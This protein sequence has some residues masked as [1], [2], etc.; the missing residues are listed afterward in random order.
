MV[1]FPETRC[2]GLNN[3]C[4]ANTDENQT[5]LHQACDDG[6]QGQ[7]KGTGTFECDTTSESTRNGPAM[8]DVTTQGKAPDASETC[9][10]EDNDCDGKTDEGSETGSLLGQEWVDIGGGR[11][12]M[13]Y[14]ASRQDATDTQQGTLAG[15]TVSSLVA[16][17]AGA[18]ES[19]TTATFTTVAPHG[20]AVGQKVRV[21]GVAVS[22]YN[23]IWTVAT[24]PAATTFTATVTT[25]GLAA[26]G[27]GSVTKYIGACSKAG[28]QPWT[29]VT[30]PEA[31]AV[32]ESMGASLCSEIRWH[33]ACSVVAPKDVAITI[34]GGTTSTSGTRI[35]AEDYYKSG[36]AGGPETGAQCAAGDT[37]DDDGDGR[38]NDGCPVNT[39]GGGESG[40]QCTNNNDDDLDGIVND[41]CPTQERGA[42]TSCNDSTD[43]DGDGF[44]NDGCPSA[45]GG[46]ETGGSSGQCGNNT[47]DDGDGRINDGCDARF[48]GAETSCRD[49]DDD[50]NDGFVNDGCPLRGNDPETACNDAVDD[51]NDGRINDGCPTVTVGAESGAQCNNNTDDDGD[52]RIND[53][54]PAL[55]TGVG[56]ETGADCS[57]N[58]DDDGD[59]RIND[60]CTAVI[61]GAGA[62]TGTQCTNS[63][64]DDNDGFVNDGCPDASSGGES[65]SQCSDTTDN[66]SNGFINDGCPSIGPQAWQEDYTNA[67]QPNSG[68]ANMRAL[69]NLGANISLGNALAQSPYLEYR[70]NLPQTAT[71]W[72]VWVRM[73]VASGSGDNTVHLGVSTSTTPVAPTATLSTST[74]DQWVWVSSGDLNIASGEQYVRLFMAEDGV[75]IDA[76]FIGRTSTPQ[77]PVGLNSAGATWSYATS[78]TMY[79]A[80]VCN[81]A[82]QSAANDDILATGTLTSCYAD[83]PNGDVF[84]MSGNVKE[85]TLARLPGQN[86]I[87]GGSSNDTATGISC[88]LNFILGTDTF[89]FPN[90]G[91]RCCK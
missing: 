31:L 55:I 76:I 23:G 89:F 26:S 17:P 70:V 47:D 30:Y 22:G 35:E 86:P 68:I 1:Q 77:P 52:G 69:P 67:P 20:L 15:V 46:G 27:G 74:T 40:S 37:T 16:D 14:E 28:A 75:K 43:N 85:W 25:S 81:G 50:D 3:D 12:I 34:D 32:C 53:G 5:N 49:N 88:Q 72:R 54:C 19:G 42:E 29:N 90:V 7:C 83:H 2:D 73:Y 61:T 82:D 78:P 6:G 87:R 39:T 18:A 24:A 80:S 36:Y 38:V 10:D 58:Q 57:D 45:Q 84:D 51:D 41:G 60:G 8:C 56:P 13:K 48:V 59:G 71:N 65:G 33:E 44:I 91:F 79:Q 21:S 63:S 64:D 66:D 62:E 9:D 11:Q 4:D